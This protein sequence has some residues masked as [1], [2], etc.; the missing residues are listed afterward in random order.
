MFVAMGIQKVNQHR[1][2]KAAAAEAKGYTVASF[3]SPK[4][5]VAPDLVLRPNTFV[6]E[7]AFIQPFV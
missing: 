1:A 5:K 7:E 3:L 4:A 2:A 6:M